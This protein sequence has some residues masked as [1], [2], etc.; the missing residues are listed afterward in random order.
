MVKI[1]AI[2]AVLLALATTSVA[3]Q[4]SNGCVDI[5]K[6]HDS[7]LFDIPF[8]PTGTP[9]LSRFGFGLNHSDD[10]NHIKQIL[11][12]PGLPAGMMRVD[13]SDDDPT[14]WFH[15]DDYC[16]NVTH[17]DITDTRI[18]QVSRGLDL[19]DHASCTVQLDKPAGDFVF[20]LI[21]FQLAY[22][23]HDNH[24]KE[25][26]ILENNGQLTVTFR[27]QQFDAPDD[28]FLWNVQFAWVPGDR[29]SQVGE[30]SGTRVHDRVI[31][32]IPVGQAVLRGFR[33]IYDD[34]D[35][36]LQQIGVRPNT[37]G[38]VFITYRDQNGDDL[39]DWQYRWA[40]LKGLDVFPGGVFPGGVVIGPAIG[41]PENR[42]PIAP[43]K[44]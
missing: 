8:A 18:R 12:W 14:G 38:S 42:S 41:S 29:F 1:A 44:K 7:S 27:D 36:H 23:Y 22:R 33:F 31:A 4:E 9:L 43:E 2:S 25:V 5:S 3:A 37:G 11:V 26:A 30:S 19:C 40:I 39:F 6:N 21:A 24:I 32:T 34:A 20:V 10:D 16:F 28:R 15:N 17:F 35:H 13:F